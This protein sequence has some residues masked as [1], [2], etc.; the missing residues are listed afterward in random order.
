M[1][2]LHTL[3]LS[4]LISFIP[5]FL[6]SQSLKFD[7]LTGADGL[8]HN[9]V[10]SIYQDKAGFMWFGTD[11]GLCRY[12]GYNITVF[13]N[14]PDAPN[15]LSMNKIR[16]VVE[17]PFGRL[18][19]GTYGGGL[20]CFNPDTETFR[21]WKHDPA[22]STSL[23]HDF[24]KSLY[25]D[26]SGVLWI[27]TEKG[28]SHLEVSHNPIVD[29]PVFTAWRHQ[30]DENNEDMDDNA[31]ESL[32]GDSE[33]HIWLTIGSRGV[34]RLDPES[35][36]FI[37]YRYRANAPFEAT[38]NY[39]DEIY[40]DRA[41]MLWFATHGNGLKRLDRDTGTF[42][43][44]QRQSGN[45]NSL[46]SDYLDVIWEDRASPGVYWI[47]TDGGGLNRFDPVS[48]N[49]ERW[50]HHSGDNT[51]LNSNHVAALFEDRSGVLWIG[52]IGGGIARLTADERSGHTFR[53]VKHIPGTEG[54]LKNSNVR[55]LHE[56]SGSDNAKIWFG[57]ADGLQ[58]FDQTNAHF[59]HWPIESSTAQALNSQ[60]VTAIWQTQRDAVWLGTDG[61]GL[62]KFNP[63]TGE[64]IH[65]LNHPENVNGIL[66]GRRINSLFEDSAGMLW[67][68]T[69]GGGLNRY[70]PET[71]L[72]TS[73]WPDASKPM[74]LNNNI[75]LCIVEDN[76]QRI[77]LGTTGG[78]IN[79]LDAGED[80]FSYLKN[81]PGNNQSLSN[82]FVTCIFRDHAG[83][84]W[85]GTE[86][87]LN[88]YIPATASFKQYTEKD[89]LPG[90]LISGIV[91]DDQH[92][93]WISTQ[94]GLSHFNPETGSFR[95]FDR[96]DGLPGGEFNAGSSLKTKTGRLFFGSLSGFISFHP[97]SL[98]D[99]MQI[100]QIMLTDFQISNKSVPILP[101]SFVS[102]DTPFSLNKHISR[103]EEI[104]LAHEQNVISFEFTALDFNAPLKNSYAYK[105]DGFDTDWIYSGNRRFVTYTNLDP[106]T[107]F[108]RVKGANNDG[109]WNEKGTSVRLVI[110]PPWWKTGWAYAL[111]AVCIAALLFGFHRFDLRNVALAHDLER[112]RFAAARLREI[113]EMKTRFFANISHEFRTPLTLILGQIKNT[114][115]SEPG[116]KVMNYLQMASRN[117]ERLLYLIN[118][119][120]DISKLEAG[121][122]KL[123]AVPGDIVAFVKKNTAIF[124]SLAAQ[125]N[126]ALSF[127]YK[128]QNIGDDSQDIPLLFDPKKMEHILLNL[129]SNAFK[130]TPAGGRIHVMVTEISHSPAHGG[131]EKNGVFSKSKDGKGA[132][133]IHIC[134][135]GAGIPAD[136]IPYIFDRF[137]QVEDGMT[138]NFEGS[139][140]GLALVQELV[141][142]HH[143]TIRVQSVVDQE[144]TFV[145]TLPLGKAH[146]ND[147]EI[148]EQVSGEDT[149]SLSSVPMEFRH[150]QKKALLSDQ[151][152][153][154]AN[155]P[156]ADATIILVVEDNP[157][158]RQFICEQLEEDFTVIEAENGR[159]GFEKAEATIPDLVISDVMMPEM[160]GFQLCDIL[161]SSLKTNHIPVI[162]LTARAGV[163]N[164]MRG[165][166][167]GADD[168][169][170]KPFDADE[171]KIR[172]QN[173]IKIRR[174]M[175]EKFSREMAFKPSRTKAPSASQEFMK[176]VLAVI[177][178]HFDDG[179]FNVEALAT[180]ISMSRAQLHRKLKAI[181]NQSPSDV[182]RI[183]RL[184][185][186]AMLLAQN[187]G[188]VAEIAYKAGFNSQ[189]YF[190]RCFQAE[191]G[192][193]PG[194]YKKNRAASSG[195]SN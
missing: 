64:F 32:A 102:K 177:E 106:G 86:G 39:V 118:Q 143:G 122:M 186:A 141:H 80:T 4:L 56:A 13:E 173:L 93:L 6:F 111:Y 37:N 15:S 74:Q 190:T 38:S 5:Q 115:A 195:S 82:N 44:W 142:V 144:T 155:A 156:E 20:N 169:L 182:L 33:G 28:L 100:P 14:R 25:L 192:C 120:L 183:Y 45:P 31:I 23:H 1:M 167:K 52:T 124:E 30:P 107:Y 176:R 166:E 164:K 140:I 95:N 92:R 22:D 130:F 160:D 105:M 139:G 12:D 127:E 18:W 119:L 158:L 194:E 58:L 152:P 19:I 71:D 138:R 73:W 78:G 133:E 10:R 110:M 84:L 94:N 67:I 79:I 11:A 16:S 75:I 145:V 48:G 91:E 147:D 168:Y 193:S 29:H 187:A 70:N 76:E 117:G 172:V 174:Q 72:F 150:L 108:F 179:D 137:Y 66:R 21:N 43:S 189:S 170:L 128:P 101:E 132:V 123:M 151:K 26:A 41:G 165:L 121:Q 54:G 113:D 188:N 191:F 27:G 36:Q 9:T 184:Q 83:R 171:L 61:D 69:H 40:F 90:A 146:L 34:D 148:Q 129:L 159:T 7:R 157:D 163:E 81:E 116:S 47:G 96:L 88:L 126:I 17:D 180:A 99:N 3:Y 89:G 109:I 87:G 161:K 97:D 125:D 112:Q 134:N 85:I 63:T 103:T 131:L 55:S 49:F 114:M 68:G 98:R 60:A 57:T 8:A 51:S 153:A 136:K 24:I 42:T 175:R 59:S 181:T 154:A 149:F 178:N 135:S 46:S 77:W 65:Y 35:G 185:H 104:T 2:I 53:K 162:L 50:L 62:K